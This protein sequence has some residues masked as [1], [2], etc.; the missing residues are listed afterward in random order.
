MKKLLFLLLSLGL[1]FGCSNDQSTNDSSNNNKT[2]NNASE[3]VSQEEN[4]ETVTVV[5]SKNNGEEI[6]EE[7]EIEIE[8]GKEV[9]LMDVM[10]ENFEIEEDGGFI[11]SL[12]G[13]AGS[14]EEKTFWHIS[15]NGEDLMVGAAEFKVEPDSKI[16]FDLQ[17][18][19]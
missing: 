17:K 6:I 8:A 4:A 9:T 1:L 15:V 5:V 7:K 12:N 14:N 16:E 11:N 2:D 19:E 10:K 18:W 3:N 13:I